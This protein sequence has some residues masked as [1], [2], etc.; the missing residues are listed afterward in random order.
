MSAAADQLVGADRRARN[1]YTLV[2]R[3]ADHGSLRALCQDITKSTLAPKYGAFAPTGGFNS[4]LRLFAT[5]VVGLQEKR[6]SCDY[7][8]LFRVTKS[9]TI[10]EIS[11]ARA[12][13]NLFQQ[14]PTEEK[15]IFLSLLLFKAR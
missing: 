3:S 12:A 4:D 11:A 10:L 7:D 15:V 6:H 5:S 2:Y 9:D 1:L 13:L 14:V 8:P